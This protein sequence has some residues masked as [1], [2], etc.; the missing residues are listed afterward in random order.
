MGFPNRAY[1]SGLSFPSQGDL[2]DQGIEPSS[3][4]LQVDSLPTEPS[5]G[6]LDRKGVY[7]QDIG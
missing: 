3:P 6:N 1:W 2:P 5:G 7:W 4:A